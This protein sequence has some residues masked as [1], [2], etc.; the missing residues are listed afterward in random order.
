MNTINQLLT[1]D[2]FR[3]SVFARDQYTCV[4]C[5]KPAVDARH[6]L[7]RRLWGNS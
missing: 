6:I 3:E 7:E 5:N 1:R 4:F 2:E